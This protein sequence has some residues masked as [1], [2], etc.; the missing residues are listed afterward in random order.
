MSRESC[1]TSVSSIAGVGV[2]NGTFG[3]LLQGALPGD[4]S[5][6]LVTLPIRRFSKV[7]FR[8]EPEHRDLEVHPTRKVKTARLARMLLERLGFPVR[9]RIEV[10]SQLPEGK[11]LASSSA[12]L[13]A[14]AR[15]IFSSFR[16]PVEEKTLLHL[17]RDIEPT[18]GVMYPELVSFFHRRVELHQRLG[19][20]ERP[21]HVVA[22]DEGGM[23]DTVAYNRRSFDYSEP[24]R[25]E[26]EGLL[27]RTI[28]AVERQ[29]LR[30]LGEIA[31]RSSEMNQV[32]N[33]KQ[34]LETMLRLREDSGALGVVVTHSGPCLGL[35]FDDS[36]N[37]RQARG[38]V[39]EE[40]AARGFEMLELSTMVPEH[41]PPIGWDPL[42]AEAPIPLSPQS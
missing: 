21:L 4:D 10:Q 1:E 6:F 18:D 5:H 30:S 17:L 2:A 23:V 19:L 26:Y 7:S 36:E 14:T 29:D 16:S 20:F 34:H 35:L 24:E 12:D 15:A 31:T 9:G 3:E 41:V 28:E 38:Y 27:D 40:V 42:P 33:P 11:G 32:R 25:K 39:V 37:H 8:A 13:V 22:I